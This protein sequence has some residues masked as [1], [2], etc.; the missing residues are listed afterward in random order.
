MPYIDETWA[1]NAFQALRRALD[2]DDHVRKEMIEFLMEE[3]FWASNMEWASALAKWN[4]CL[5]PTKA[6]FFKVGELWAL[7]RR[8]ERHE[9]FLAMAEDLGYEV[10][11]RPT[12]ERR[13][14]LLERI[15]RV[16]GDLVMELQSTRAELERL[17]A[18]APRTAHVQASGSGLPR[19][20]LTESTAPRTAV[21]RIG[22]P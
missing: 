14:R 11:R 16:Q 15:D 21:E 6:E 19:F 20:A 17:E 5:N 13:L 3:G 2:V 9:L 12:E 8:F 4:S 7:A 10:R 1:R 18:P 22:C